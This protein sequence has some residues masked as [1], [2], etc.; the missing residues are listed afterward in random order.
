LRIE[1]GD[2]ALTSPGRIKA[3]NDRSFVFNPGS[4]GTSRVIQLDEGCGD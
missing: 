3:P 4:T 2:V 1:L